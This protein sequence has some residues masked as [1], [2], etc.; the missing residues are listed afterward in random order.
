M[1]FNPIGG[2]VKSRYSRGLSRGLR[3]FGVSLMRRGASLLRL[4]HRFRG[5]IRRRLLDLEIERA[6]HDLGEFLYARLQPEPL[7]EGDLV[8]L[9][10]LRT[11]ILRLEE[12][13]RLAEAA[14]QGEVRIRKNRKEGV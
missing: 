4:D 2:S 10:L 1:A 14:A 7:D 9:D 11:E 8:L 12:E 5:G 6:T 13:R 3:R